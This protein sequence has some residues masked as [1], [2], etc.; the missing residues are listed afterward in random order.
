MAIPEQETRPDTSGQPGTETARAV[1][2]RRRVVTLLAILGALT[3]AAGGAFGVRAVIVRH[4]IVSRFDAQVAAH[5]AAVARHETAL[6]EAERTLARD[7][8]AGDGMS[9][10]QHALNQALNASRK[11]MNSCSSARCFDSLN[12]AD[13]R[14]AA[15]FGRATGAVS[16]PAGASALVRRLAA[17]TAE[18]Q[19]SWTYMSH[20]TSLIDVEKRAR[21]SEETESQFYAADNALAQWLKNQAAALRR[22]ETVLDR[23]AAA[24]NQSG[25]LL[26]RRGEALGL[27]PGVRT[28]RSSQEPVTSA[29]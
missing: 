11:R 12:V 15:A 20:S 1:T 28:A 10:A 25:D 9:R 14:A 29:A 8:T 4:R 17:E 21:L 3:V 2:R 24:L 6:S 16:V 22:E 7:D 18:Y 13:A 23:Q 27:Q 19:R 26:R 5:N